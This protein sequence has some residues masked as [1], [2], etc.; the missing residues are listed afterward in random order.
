MQILIS[1]DTSCTL[2]KLIFEVKRVI[3]MW[4]KLAIVAVIIFIFILLL[5]F[6]SGAFGAKPS[7][8]DIFKKVY[9]LSP[10]EDVKI[11][12]ETLGPPQEKVGRFF[13]I[14]PNMHW[15]F[16]P[17]RRLIVYLTEDSNIDFT[18]YHESYKQ[19]K[20][21]RARCKELREGFCE[22][23]G[24]PPLGDFEDG[25]IWY[26]D[27]YAWVLIPPKGEKDMSVSIILKLQ[28]RKNK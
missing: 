2:L 3:I 27:E 1:D 15:I 23:F 13:S 8:L 25:I 4:K 22:I 5:N 28:H 21:A 18:Y 19:M 11:A 17:D 24:A 9:P 14:P 26:V 10:G 20:A 7:A 12:Y 6:S 16:W